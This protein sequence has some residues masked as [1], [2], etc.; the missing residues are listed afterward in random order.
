MQAEDTFLLKVQQLRDLLQVRHCVML[1]GDAGAGKS[2]VWKVL[3]ACMNIGQARPKAVYE[4]VN[5]KSVSTDELY[6]YMTLARV[7]TQRCGLC[8]PPA[9]PCM[10]CDRVVAT[11]QEW[12]DG[13]LSTLMRNMSQKLAP[14]SS[15]QLSQWIV[16][17]GEIDAD[18]IEVCD[19]L[20]VM[21]LAAAPSLM[22]SLQFCVL[23]TM[24][25]LSC[26]FRA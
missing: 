14:Y 26:V 7:R 25:A 20:V 24:L 15:H 22:V 12:V 3:T 4:I 23:L 21:T 10:S 1:L 18:W 13:V 16:L 5:P 19:R 2:S 11:S 9:S 6:G 17:D 8:S